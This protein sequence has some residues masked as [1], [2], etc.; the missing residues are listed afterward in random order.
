MWLIEFMSALVFLFFVLMFMAIPIAIS[1]RYRES[2]KRWVKDPKSYSIWKAKPTTEAERDIVEAEWKLED[3]REK[4]SW[5]QAK[6]K[7]ESAEE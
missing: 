1:Y 3:A 2:I 4:L 5:H 7:E 6:E